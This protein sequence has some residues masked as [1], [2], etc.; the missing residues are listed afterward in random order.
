MDRRLFLAGVASCASG[1]ALAQTDWTR[2]AVPAYTPLHLVLGLHKHWTLPRAEAFLAAAQRLV[3]RLD[4]PSWGEAMLLWERLAMPALGPVVA[5]RSLRQIDFA[6]SRPALIARAV[7]AAP[8]ELAALE[9][10]GTP[11]KGLPALEQLLWQQRP[12]S[13]AE[14]RYAQLLAEELLNEAR[15]LQAGFAALAAREAEDWSEEDALAGTSELLNQWV[16]GV[17]RLRW[18]QME[19]PL[20]SGSKDALPRATSG[21]TAAAWAAEW[22]SLRGLALFEGRQAPAP[23]AGL[24]PL[25][26]Y[27]RGRG[28]NAVAD[29]LRNT[30]LAADAKLQG[31][32]PAKP[33]PVLAAAKALE[34]LK[35]LVQDQ[36][37]PALDLSLGFSDADGD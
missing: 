13:E 35:R 25:E 28:R 34:A 14:R 6:P 29:A 23:G 21:L 37:A 11:A 36:V 31:L 9:R 32:S 1:A 16:G 18:A 33:Q 8:R 12:L 10:I 22:Q 20:R 24:V 5:R 26:T 27:L 7:Q 30:V 2:E 15:A 17:E 19:K 3:E 4:R